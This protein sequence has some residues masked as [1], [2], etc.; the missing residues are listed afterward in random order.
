MLGASLEVPV[1]KQRDG[2]RVIFNDRCRA[3][4]DD[5]QLLGELAT[6]VDFLSA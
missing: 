4:L 1:F 6:K 2:A 5:A 3:R